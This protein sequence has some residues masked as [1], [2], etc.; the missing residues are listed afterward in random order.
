MQTA[1][2]RLIFSLYF[3]RGALWAEHRPSP[4]PRPYFYPASPPFF[5][6]I[7][8]K[9]KIKTGPRGPLQSFGE[10]GQVRPPSGASK[11]GVDVFRPLLSEGGSYKPLSNPWPPSVLR[12][13]RASK[14][15]S[16]PLGTQ[17]GAS[18]ATPSGSCGCEL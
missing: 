10:G 7:F 4:F 1:V 6:F 5:I 17:R 13:R 11:A 14:A 18:K 2:A 12:R 16:Y 8:V 15:P 3:W 9:I